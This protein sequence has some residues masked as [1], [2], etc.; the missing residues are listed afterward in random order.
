LDTHLTDLQHQ[1]NTD[2]IANYTAAA[3]TSSGVKVLPNRADMAFAA[4]ARSALAIGTPLPAPSGVGRNYLTPADAGKFFDASAVESQLVA[5]TA[6]PAISGDL[7]AASRA[8]VESDYEATMTTAQQALPRGDRQ[9]ILGGL[10]ALPGA[11]AQP[12]LLTHPLPQLSSVVAQWILDA[13]RFQDQAPNVR[14]G[15][16][17]DLN[18]I[19]LGLQ[20][21]NITD[22]DV[23]G[24]IVEGAYTLLGIS[25]PQ[26]AASAANPAYTTLAYQLRLSLD[27]QFQGP[28]PPATPKMLA[29]LSLSY[30]PPGYSG[31][32]PYC[33]ADTAASQHRYLNDE[34]AFDFF[35]TTNTHEHC[36]WNDSAWNR[37]LNVYATIKGLWSAEPARDSDGT[38]TNTLDLARR[39]LN[40][41]AGTGSAGS[42]G[43]GVSNPDWAVT[44]FAVQADQRGFAAFEAWAKHVPTLSAPLLS[45]VKTIDAI[46]GRLVG[47]VTGIEPSLG[48]QLTNAMGLTAARE[49][50]ASITLADIANLPNASDIINKALADALYV[51]LAETKNLIRLSALVNNSYWSYQNGDF[52]PPRDAITGKAPPLIPDAVGA[53]KAGAPDIASVL[54]KGVQTY[55]PWADRD[56]WGFLN[57]SGAI[58]TLVAVFGLIAASFAVDDVGLTSVHD[59]LAAAQLFVS[60]FSFPTSVLRAMSYLYG[61]RAGISGPRGVNRTDTAFGISER[62]FADTVKL[63][64]LNRQ[65]RSYRAAG[66]L[67]GDM[68]ILRRSGQPPLTVP[69][70]EAYLRE[71]HGLRLSTNSITT[72]LTL[73]PDFV[74]QARTRATDVAGVVGALDRANVLVALEEELGGAPLV[75]PDKNLSAAI[76]RFLAWLGYPSGPSRDIRTAAAV[77]VLKGAFSDLTPPTARQVTA[78]ILDV[79]VDGKA[80]GSLA[81]IT[82]N[83]N[84]LA[85][86]GSQDQKLLNTGMALRLANGLSAQTTDANWVLTRKIQI[87]TGIMGAMNF[88]DLAGGILGVSAA[89]EQF[90]QGGLNALNTLATALSLTAG[91][92][93]ILASVFEFLGFAA[94]TNFGFLAALVLGGLAALISYLSINASRDNPEL[95]QWAE[96]FRLS[97]LLRPGQTQHQPDGTYTFPALQWWHAHTEPDSSHETPW[98][99]SNLTGTQLTDALRPADVSSRVSIESASG[100]GCLT[101]PLTAPAAPG[102]PT[103]PTAAGSP[104]MRDCVT[105][106]REQVFTDAVNNS[107]GAHMFTL[108]VSD[109][110]YPTNLGAAWACPGNLGTSSTVSTLSCRTDTQHTQWQLQ[111]V[112]DN[113]G[114]ARIMTPDGSSCMTK[115]P[116][117]GLQTA[118]CRPDSDPT[119]ANQWWYTNKVDGYQLTQ[120]PSSRCLTIA[121][122]WAAR[123]TINTCGRATINIAQSFFY[124]T[125]IGSLPDGTQITMLQLNDDTCIQLTSANA[126]NATPVHGG[127]CADAYATPVTPDGW[128][129]K[130]QTDGSAIIAYAGSLNTSGHPQYCLDTADANTA[131]NSALVIGDCTPSSRTQRWDL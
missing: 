72:I 42:A 86:D 61:G 75:E 31:Q 5:R 70:I 118:P 107:N 53:A 90:M 49:A 87:G 58:N 13:A 91:L 62:A 127:R 1:G 12:D 23:M 44:A 54:K 77:T 120:A 35:R 8:T 105:G 48:Q 98:P 29:V 78:A 104:T 34:G 113:P 28:H 64:D 80:P 96:P 18:S 123:A 67:F 16:G 2:L 119:S 4:T 6:D 114:A 110:A 109:T 82:H 84:L 126:H 47:Y 93:G 59:D 27:P 129:I 36:T 121:D 94:A 112:T 111:S 10:W 66:T 69:Q 95:R 45:Q 115:D 71:V 83:G 103:A 128:I 79:A 65:E 55:Q 46:Q 15:P 26:I 122:A 25:T 9:H 7:I 63:L 30:G 52:D 102:S 125:M 92:A 108:D 20:R 19:A 43:G 68:E 131:E 37:P 39:A 24:Q 76:N 57:K 81:E 106:D 56:A 130:P 117:T 85:A 3:Q 116:A 89:V 40:S 32:L 99:A 11:P 17:H 100:Q 41:S 51:A 38:W 22:Y 124:P 50:Y 33:Y 88:L 101:L 73:P 97:G 60:T 14:S 21:D 74:Q